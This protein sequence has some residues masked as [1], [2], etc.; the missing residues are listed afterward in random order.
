MTLTMTSTEGHTEVT[1]VINVEDASTILD[2]WTHA[3]RAEN[4]HWRDVVR[5]MQRQ[6]NTGAEY[7]FLVE[8]G[9][10][11]DFDILF[12]LGERC[13]E[14]PDINVLTAKTILDSS[15]GVKGIGE[16]VN[17]HAG[18]VI[19]GTQEEAYV[20]DDTSTS[21]LDEDTYDVPEPVRHLT[22]FNLEVVQSG[23]TFS[24][25][26]GTNGVVV[27]RGSSGVDVQILG[28]QR[29]SR[30]HARV[31]VEGGMLFVQ[32][33]GSSGGTFVNSVPTSGAVQVE[34]GESISLYTE[35]I[36]VVERV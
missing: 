36:K 21:F 3:V 27:G 13:P 18:I 11:G 6:G 17:V 30:V 35:H 4:L 22:T 28:N 24:V 34:V 2:Y 23:Q 20:E 19:G 1:D 9:Y 31:W 26:E 33:L 7:G 29:I 15:R 16:S 32:D 14:L 5:V 25:D 8:E 10:E 12:W